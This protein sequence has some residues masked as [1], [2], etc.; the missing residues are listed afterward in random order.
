MPA[1]GPGAVGP[2]EASLEEDFTW[3]KEEMRRVAQ[4]CFII[5]DNIPKAGAD[6]YNKLVGFVTNKFEKAGR[7]RKSES[8]EPRV[9][10]VKD[11][12]GGSTGFA[13]VEYISPEEAQKALHFLHNV[14]LDR[15]HRM[16]ACTLTNLKKLQDIPDTFKPP[17]A[18][19]VTSN[20]PNYKSWLLDDRGRDQF[21]IRH[22]DETSIFWHDHVVKPQLVSFYLDL[23]TLRLVVMIS[24]SAISDFLHTKGF[25]FP[26]AIDVW[27]LV[28]AVSELRFE[29]LFP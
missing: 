3:K 14:N 10:V 20:R 2:T 19:P 15:T 9:N 22:E 21:L 8:G 18:L 29:N 17:Q 11:E 7:V 13:T 26:C 23:F 4:D 27:I 16:W 24:L 1:L 5:V 25:A 6:K 28:E 12:Q